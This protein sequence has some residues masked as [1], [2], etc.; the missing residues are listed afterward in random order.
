MSNH[1]VAKNI[2]NLLKRFSNYKGLPE[3]FFIPI[4]ILILI[5]LP[6]F[7]DRLSYQTWSGQILQAHST[8]GE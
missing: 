3:L 1:L 7:F 8:Y 2:F 5:P 6:N 4:P